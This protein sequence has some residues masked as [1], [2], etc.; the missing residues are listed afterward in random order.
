M[1]SEC[2]LTTDDNPWDPFDNFNEWYAY[3]TKA[4]HHSLS[5]L[6]RV[7]VFSDEVSELDQHVAIE[8]AID[9]VVT[10]NVSGVHKK[11]SRETEDSKEEA[12]IV[13]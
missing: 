1:A 8:L 5:L 2:M 4:G 6:A 11:V 10:E 12:E 13:G 9:E 7:V 3:D